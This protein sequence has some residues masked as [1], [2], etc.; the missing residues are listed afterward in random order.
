MQT[1]LKPRS[2][3]QHQRLDTT[4]PHPRDTA[5]SAAAV[6]MLMPALL[7]G[8]EGFGRRFTEGKGAKSA[9]RNP[10]EGIFSQKCH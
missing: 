5:V 1:Q 8:S 6:P 4:A 3:A 2:P 7:S 9:R 10:E